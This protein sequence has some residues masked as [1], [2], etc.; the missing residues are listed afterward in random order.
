MHIT[1]EQAQLIL[2]WFEAHETALK[3]TTSHEYV[4]AADLA[5]LAGDVVA[6]ESYVRCA[7]DELNR[8]I[9]ESAAKWEPE[10]TPKRPM[11][12]GVRV[13]RV[14]VRDKKVWTERQ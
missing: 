10:P 8:E 3:P 5:K 11:P 4:F 13:I 1:K 7:F 2:H 12:E 6:E 9:E 14:N